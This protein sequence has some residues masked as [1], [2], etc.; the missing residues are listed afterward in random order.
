MVKIVRCRVVVV[1]F[2]LVRVCCSDRRSCAVCFTPSL[3]HF[4]SRLSSRLERFLGFAESWLGYASK[5]TYNLL[6][7]KN[8]HTLHTSTAMTSFFSVSHLCSEFFN[9]A[10]PN[11]PTIADFRHRQ[12]SSDGDLG[13]AKGRSAASFGGCN[14]YNNLEGW[15]TD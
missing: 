12:G 3:N 9:E 8:V 2:F 13:A 1:G 11:H 7:I 5:Y 14:Q 10:P 15:L 4:V 6:K